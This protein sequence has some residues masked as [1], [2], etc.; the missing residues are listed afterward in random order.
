MKR[1]LIHMSP[2]LVGSGVSDKIQSQLWE[3]V[4]ADLRF[5]NQSDISGGSAV[6]QIRK[7]RQK[8]MNRTYLKGKSLTCRSF[9]VPLF[10]SI[11]LPPEISPLSDINW[12]EV[13]E[14]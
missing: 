8:I 3:H 4:P 2:Q 7:N 13:V 14:K 5:L 6:S 11:L 9:A 12:K 10:L 1:D